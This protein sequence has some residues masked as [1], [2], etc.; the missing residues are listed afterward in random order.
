MAGP[1]LRVLLERHREAFRRRDP[2]AIAA[3]HHADAVVVSPLFATARG[4][5]AIEAAY[6]SLFG[7]FPDME[8]S[9]DAMVVDPPHVASFETMRATHRNEFLGYPR[10]NRPVE[11]TLARLMTVEDG[12]IMHHRVVYD[13]TGWLVQAG[14]LQAKPGKP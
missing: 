14:V 12:L 9:L 5:A 6:A 7:S 8:I 1:E 2:A 4:R 10:T 3:C 11:M 13:F